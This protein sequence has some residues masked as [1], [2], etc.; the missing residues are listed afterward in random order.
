[1]GL[2]PS[3][4]SSHCFFPFLSSFGQLFPFGERATMGSSID[5]LGWKHSFFLGVGS[6]FIY[7]LLS[8]YKGEGEVYFDSMTMVIVFVLLGKLIE[9]KVKWTAKESLFF[10]HRA[11]PRRGRK[12]FDNGDKFVSI[13]EF[14]PRDRLVVLTGEK[15]VLDGKIVEGRATIDESLMTG[16]AIPVEKGAG[17][18]VIG[19]SVLQSGWLVAQVDGDEK[20]SS[21]YHIL[22]AVADPLNA[23]KREVGPLNSLLKWFVPLI[24]FLSLMTADFDRGIATLLIACPCAIGIAIPLAESKWIF[25][26]SE[27]GIVVRNRAVL[28]LI[29]KQ[30]LWAFDKTG[31]LTE[32]KLT[33]SSKLPEENLAVLKALAMHS[34]HPVSQAVYQAISAKAAKL[35][36]VEEVIGKGVKGW[37]DGK[38]Y[39][40]GSAEFVG[41]RTCGSEK[42]TA[43]FSNPQQVYRLEFEDSLRE[44]AKELVQEIKS[45]LLSGDQSKVVERVAKELNLKHWK[46]E[47]SPED[48]REYIQERQREG[49]IIAMMGDGVNDAPALAQANLSLTPF[50]ATDISRAASDLYLTKPGL[51]QLKVLSKIGQR[52]NRIVKQNLFWAFFYNVIG[53]GLAFFGFLTPLFATSAMV[54]SSLI[55]IFNSK[56]L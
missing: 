8:L 25:R 12:R 22:E 28:P 20:T 51:S 54:L 40:L 52:G 19:G 21:L 39:L 23:K 33:L 30:T 34:Q 37:V 42:T 18:R 36:S 32:G 29:G 26:L 13:K 27:Q 41:Y 16:E 14:K 44:G 11:L 55:V 47:M 7:S 53:V 50:S 6:S 10:M 35:D 9:S 48:K 2:G 31:T 46:G 5:L 4:A 1:M 15:I 49:E 3:F 17:D 45:V 38:M 24:V 56:R 43:F